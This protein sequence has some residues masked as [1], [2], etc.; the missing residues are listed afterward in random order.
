[1]KHATLIPAYG[2]DYKSK[3]AV[4]ADLLLDKDFIMRTFDAPDAYINLSQL[5]E[6]GCTTVNVRYDRGRKVAVLKVP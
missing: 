6:L 3:P 1:M 5:R 4:A 2:R